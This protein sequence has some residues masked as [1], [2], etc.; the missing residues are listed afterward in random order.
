[1]CERVSKGGIKSPA[2]IRVKSTQKGIALVL[3]DDSA[4]HLVAERC[5]DEAMALADQAGIGMALAK[6]SNFCGGLGYYLHRAAD[7][8]Y[9]CMFTTNSY[10]KV[11]AHGG[12]QPV[13]GTNPFGFA[14]PMQDGDHLIVDLSTSA[15]AGSTVTHLSEKG[16]AL[17]EGVAIDV[18]GDPLTDPQAIQQGAILPMG[19]AKGFGLS[20]MVEI[21]SALLVGARSTSSLGSLYGDSSSPGGNGH[22]AICV[23]VDGARPAV[24]FYDSIMELKAVL[25]ASGDAVRLPGA[26]RC[27]NL[28][29]AEK[30]G[31]ALSEQTAVKLRSIAQLY[32]LTSPV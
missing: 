11:V 13:L 17:P 24:G 2:Q 3:G 1:M 21:L 30:L 7:R 20:V 27:Q 18:N 23:R 16:A 5:V 9:V 12:E 4:G 10:P 26:S 22:C 19:G 31:I 29:T 28:R 25:E 6:N 15:S 32:G 8:G 14:A